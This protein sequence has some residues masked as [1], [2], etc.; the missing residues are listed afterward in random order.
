MKVLFTTLL[1]GACCC[2][3][4][5]QAGD[6]L[7]FRGDNSQGKYNETALL[8]VWPEA[9]LTPKW[10]NSELGA[11]WSSVIKVGDKLYVNCLD[12][13]DAKYESVVCLDLDGKKKGQT[14]VGAVWSAA[15]QEPR[16]TPTYADGRLVVLSGAGE[17]FCV[18]AA[19][20]KVLWSKEVAKTYETRFGMW[21]MAESV[22]VKDGKIFITVCGKKA[23]AAALSLADGSE[24]WTTPSNGDQCAYVSQI[25]HDNV[26]IVMTAKNVSGVDIEN[27]KMLW[28]NSYET[29]SGGPVRR[30]G[31]NCNAPLVKGNRFF[32][33]AGYDQGGVMYEIL[34]DRKGVKVAWASKALDPHHGG[35]VEVDGRIYGSNWL[36]NNAGNW[37]CLDWDTGKTIY[38]EPWPNL[39]KGVVIFADGMLYLYEEKRGTLGLAKASDKFE[40]VS[41][42]PVTFGARQHWAHPVVSDGVLYVRR[43]NALAAF[44]LKKK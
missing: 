29:A 37:V 6:V 9:G 5:L 38:E 1:S 26:L 40:V 18:N 42:F 4:L 20:G 10:L 32:V 14:R 27:G 21:G 12:E 44:D 16:A 13:T 25:I 30:G 22:I 3:S 23:L 36:N 15:Y 34:P 28:S 7:R 17:L 8:K 43:G 33:T 11:G 24:I 41:S 31:I 35:A 39:G 19:D 2:A